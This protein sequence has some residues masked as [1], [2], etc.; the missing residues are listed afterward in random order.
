M[1]K[2]INKCLNEVTLFNNGSTIKKAS[3]TG[4][5]IKTILLSMYVKVS[6]KIIRIMVNII[7]SRVFNSPVTRAQ[8]FFLGF[9]ISYFF[10]VILLMDM[11]A[12]LAVMATKRIK[13]YF[14]I[15]KWPLDAIKA[16][17]KIKGRSNTVCSS[18]IHSINAL[19]LPVKIPS[20]LVFHFYIKLLLLQ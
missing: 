20:F 8:L 1:V 19:I 12:P 4:D 10:P 6:N 11:A 16:P 14:I 9:I 13:K 7:A 17:A 3:T 2:P 5:K 18:L 15:S